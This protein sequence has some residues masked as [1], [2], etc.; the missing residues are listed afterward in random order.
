MS[1]RA[2]MKAFLIFALA[3]P[4]L[5]LVCEWVAGLLRAMGDAGAAEVLGHVCSAARV[6]WLVSLAG[7]VILL[8]IESLNEPREE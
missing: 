6:L 2:A 7:L 4:V 8:A 3:L 1:L 5:L